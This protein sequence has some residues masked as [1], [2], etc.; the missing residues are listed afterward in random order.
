M[1]RYYVI[2]LSL[3][4]VIF[5][6]GRAAAEDY[7]LD[8][9]LLS[10]EV[11]ASE[12]S[13]QWGSL[14]DELVVQPEHQEARLV[15]GISFQKDLTAD[16]SSD[17]KLVISPGRLD[18]E[19]IFSSEL[20]LGL[21]R[22]NDF[23]LG[24]EINSNWQ[25]ST[26]FRVDNSDSLSSEVELDEPAR[27]EDGLQQIGIDYNAS[28][29]LSLFVNY[30]KEERSATSQN[31]TAIG[32]TYNNDAQQIKLQYQVDE[33]NGKEYS[34]TGV[35]WSVNEMTTVEAAYTVVEE[36]QLDSTAEE[37]TIQQDP[38][39]SE[40]LNLG[41]DLKLSQRASLELGYQLIDRETESSNELEKVWEKLKPNAANVELKI[42]F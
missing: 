20:D 41:L 23:K 6:W 18:D 3:I 38:L 8:D 25:L 28:E 2:L 34:S 4:L 26:G 15:K 13:L 30:F 40:L 31:S 37:L 7:K 21:D 1:R 5:L 29:D 11:M 27:L 19:L 32:V 35:E 42:N 24:Y 39:K 22:K 14:V 9:Q 36:S 10:Q 17:L 16:R 33:F 12:D